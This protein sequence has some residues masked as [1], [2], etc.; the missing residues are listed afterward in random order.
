MPRSKPVPTPNTQTPMTHASR[1]SERNGE[2]LWSV[3][4]VM[5]K[6]GLSRASI[7]RYVALDLFPPQRRIGPGRIAWLS[8]EV[9]VWMQ[10][11]PDPR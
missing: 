8:S 1:L 7:Y 10:T 5:Q 2:E 9:L 3:K 11:R 6:T 4:I